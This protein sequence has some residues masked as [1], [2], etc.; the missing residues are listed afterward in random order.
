M[1]RSPYPIANPPAAPVYFRRVGNYEVF[2]FD[3]GS[4]A[5]ANELIDQV[6][7][8]KTV[9]W[10]GEDPYLYERAERAYVQLFSNVFLTT[11]FSIIIGL[12]ASVCIGL[13]LGTYVF[14][15]R[16]QKQDSMTAFS[17]AGG[18][19]RLNLDGLTPDIPV[20]RLLKD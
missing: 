4:E 7:Y 12:S 15:L 14:Y 17:D 13:A 8:E 6:K 18:M 9:Q 3:A 19:T 20:D 5:A 11:M 16:K 2:V 1:R 10:L